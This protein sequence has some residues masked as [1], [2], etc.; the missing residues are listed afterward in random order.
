MTFIQFCYKQF[1]T[2]SDRNLFREYLGYQVEQEKSPAEWWDLFL[3]FQN[4][5]LKRSIKNKSDSA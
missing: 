5:L 2:E 3:D 4:W 1:I